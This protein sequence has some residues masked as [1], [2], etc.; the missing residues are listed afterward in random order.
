MM[1]TYRIA[2][3]AGDGIGPE[4]LRE[5][6]K[7]LNQAAACDGRFSFDFTYFPGDVNMIL[8]QAG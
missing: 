3:I 5:G 2:V 7:A 1:N 4:V 8:K 6:I